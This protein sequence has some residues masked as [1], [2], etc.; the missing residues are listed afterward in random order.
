MS[1]E[2]VQSNKSFHHEFC[3]NAAEEDGY[4][5]GQEVSLA[6]SPEAMELYVDSHDDVVQEELDYQDSCP[7][8][9]R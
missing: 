1:M 4:E 9:P 8:T 7:Q 2:K 3:R 5:E 6:G